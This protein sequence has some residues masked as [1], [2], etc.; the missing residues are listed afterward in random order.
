MTIENK[1]LSRI[2]ENDPTLLTLNLSNQAL[3]PSDIKELVEALKKNTYLATLDLSGNQFGDEGAVLLT[4]THITSLL[5]SANRIG[6]VGAI[7][8]SKNKNIVILDISHNQIGN[9]GASAFAKNPVLT[10]LNLAGNQI[11]YEGASPFAE[12]RWLK[13][14]DLSENQLNDLGAIVLAHNK[15]L[16]TLILASNQIGDSGAIALALHPT[17]TTLV[18]HHNNIAKIGAKALAKAT[19]LTSLDVSYNGLSIEGACAIAESV[20]LLSLFLAGND[21]NNI[22]IRKLA[23]NS[24]LTFLDISYNQVNDEGVSAFENNETIHE[25][26]IS[27]NHVTV[28]GAKVLAR[29][30]KLSVLH[31]SYNLLGDEGII[32]L[33]ESNSITELDVAGNQV[34]ARG[35]TALARNTRLLKV[36]LSYNSVHNKGAIE[37]AQNKSFLELSLSYN[38]IGDEGAIALAQNQTFRLLNLNYNYI[39]ENGRAALT[40]N[41]SFQTLLL[42]HEQPPDFT[43]EN[44]STIFTLTQ[45]LLCIRAEDDTIQFFNPTFSR[46]LGYKDDELLTKPLR[47]F[48]HP[49]DK[50][51]ESM[52]SFEEHQKFP[53]AQRIY[54]YRHKNGSYRLIQWSSQMKNGRIYASGIDITEQQQAIIKLNR[55]EQQNMISKLKIEQAALY[56]QKQ[57]HFI[58]HL[59]HEL[60]IPLSGI[61]SNVEVLQDHIKT[62]HRGLIH[63]CGLLSPPLMEEVAGVLTKI[64]ECLIDMEIC[65]EHE[66]TIL[67]DNLDIA[68]MSEH[69]LQ[70]DNIPFDLKKAV[71][72]VSRMLIG[73]AHKKGLTLNTIL[74]QQPLWVKGDPTRVKQIMLNL[75]SNA[76]KFTNQ[77]HIE[78]AVMVKDKQLELTRFEICVKDTGVGLTQ[79][80]ASRLFE[81]FTQSSNAVGDSGLGLV[82]AKG[83]AQLMGGDIIVESK[84]GEGSTFRCTIQC[85]NL[86]E[87]EQIYEETKATLST[88]S[89]A[90]PQFTQKLT[91]LIADDNVINRKLLEFILTNAGHMC[92]CA[93]DGLEAIAHYNQHRCD[94]I[95]MDILMPN[96]NGIDATREIRKLEREK[97]LLRVPIIALTGNTLEVQRQEALTAGM[98]DYATKP[99]KKTEILEK[100]ANFFSPSQKPLPPSSNQVV[101]SLRQDI[102]PQTFWQPTPKK[103]DSFP[104]ISD[105]ITKEEAEQTEDKLQRAHFSMAYEHSSNQSIIPKEKI[106]PKVFAKHEFDYTDKN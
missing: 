29:Q 25:L 52:Q 6:E 72:E 33:A 24:V 1:V 92:L 55:I 20:S 39:K 42:S 93:V 101:S 46:V 62:L 69:K 50:Y 4:L 7:A 59:C 84:Q 80:E 79:M 18:L 28:Q 10:T 22:G 11:T 47:D 12:N 35:A 100:I 90:Q 66:K 36:V 102:S 53:I 71:H 19:Q 49:D 73:R 105:L 64:E 15:N 40:Q 34:C 30:S 65:T 82:I 23:Q 14:L 60:R 77:G 8:L 56:S 98:D 38:Q 76:V 86:L 74:P 48:L 45:D 83:L 106:K 21:A 89:I 5:I 97:H 78:F 31:A 16:S 27:H 70:M 99:C 96:L 2:T 81:R 9:T 95:L 51:K 44:L 58:A 57:S 61:S 32:A 85:N 104:K 54:R 67:N 94:I 26:N 43:A 13:W 88:V 63:A 41:K 91:I 75:V 103:N 17:V 87:K 3:T 37:L 68:K